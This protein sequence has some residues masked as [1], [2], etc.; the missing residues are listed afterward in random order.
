MF[1]ERRDELSPEQIEVIDE[2]V[3]ADHKMSP[4]TMRELFRFCETIDR[5]GTAAWKGSRRWVFPRVLKRAFWHEPRAAAG[6]AL[7]L[8]SKALL[9]RAV[10]RY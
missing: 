4:T 6:R 3:G 9:H 2:Y 8:A 1:R 7:R 10:E 5:Y